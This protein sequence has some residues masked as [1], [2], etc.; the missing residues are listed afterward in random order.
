[1]TTLCLPAIYI[2]VISYNYEVIPVEIIFSIKN[3]LEYL[4]F[5]PLIE[6]A[7]MQFTLEL[8]REAAIRLQTQ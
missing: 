7:I 3:S 6:A 1:M 5:P 4:P 2:A 8:I